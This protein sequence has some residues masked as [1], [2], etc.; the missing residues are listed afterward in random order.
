MKPHGRKITMPIAPAVYHLCYG[1]PGVLLRGAPQGSGNTT[2]GGTA[3]LRTSPPILMA[4]SSQTMTHKP[5]VT[6]DNRRWKTRLVPFWQT[7]IVLRAARARNTRPRTPACNPPSRPLPTR[8][9]RTRRAMADRDPSR[10]SIRNDQ[11]TFLEKS[12]IFSAI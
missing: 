5:P 10:S 1:N 3:A 4:Q 2:S 11:T 7:S 6:M 12:P 8:S 9:S